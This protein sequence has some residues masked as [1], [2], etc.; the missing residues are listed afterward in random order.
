MSALKAFQ[1]VFYN[2][3]KVENLSDVLCP[4]YDVISKEQQDAYYKQNPHNFI[5]L[6]LAKETSKDNARDNKYT[7]AAKTYEEWLKKGVLVKDKP[8][9]IY[10]Y[11][12]DYKYLGQK[13]TRTGFLALLNIGDDA[14]VK[15]LPHEH[16]YDAAKTDRHL[17]WSS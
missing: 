12:Q 5:R 4:P 10:F 14:G 6:E 8:P 16:T 2:K 3:E 11:K 1:A 17:L 13:Y 15:V 7:R 9:C